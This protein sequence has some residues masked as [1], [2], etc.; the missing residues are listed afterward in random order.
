MSISP[1]D[2]K[3]WLEQV[4]NLLQGTRKTRRRVPTRRRLAA[5]QLERRNVLSV[6]PLVDATAFDESATSDDIAAATI[7]A[8]EAVVADAS[9][10]EAAPSESWAAEETLS[11]IV[12]SG[13]AAAMA[14]GAGGGVA[15]AYGSGSGAGSGSG[16]GSGSAVGSGSGAGTGSGSGSASGSG[17]GTPENE[18]PEISPPDVVDNGDG[19]ITVSG[20]VTDDGDLTGMSITVSGATGGTATINPDGSFSIDMPK[21]PESGVIELTVTDPEGGTTTILVPVNV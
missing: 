20:Q 13:D 4:A 6:A 21:P 10:I 16:S 18:A 14:S 12:G 19:T 7:V 8:P 3:N 11:V 17:S 5:E 1:K 2:S 15:A 9:A